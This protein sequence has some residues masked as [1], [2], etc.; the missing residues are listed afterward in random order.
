MSKPTKAK[1]FGYDVQLLTLFK[2][3]LMTSES[4]KSTCFSNDGWTIL[5]RYWN[6]D[7]NAL[8]VMLNK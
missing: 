7:K 6:I 5:D 1:L 2:Y 4:T 3:G 8:P